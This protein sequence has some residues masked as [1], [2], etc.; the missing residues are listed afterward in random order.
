MASSLGAILTLA[1]DFD[2]TLVELQQ[3]PYDQPLRWRPWAREFLLGARAA[4]VRI[5]VH[6]CR[7][8]PTAEFLGVFP[9]DTEEFWRSGMLPAPVEHHWAL[10]DRMRTFLQAE[11]VWDFVEIWDSPGKPICDRY[12]ED[13]ASDPI[14]PRVA[15]EFGVALQ[16]PSGQ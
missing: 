7:A 2:G 11:G 14:W 3:P 15:A 12:V 16:A 8:N 1:V 4:G 5:W 13:R 6:T 9:G 10:F